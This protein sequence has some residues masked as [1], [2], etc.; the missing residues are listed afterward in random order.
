MSNQVSL[1]SWIKN[2]LGINLIVQTFEKQFSNGFYFGEILHVY[3][4]NP[5]FKENFV[6]RSQP[7]YVNRNFEL[8]RPLFAN[9]LGID[10]NS[11]IVKDIIN[12]RVGV[13]KK[14]ILKMRT[15]LEDKYEDN[16]KVSN[17][18]FLTDAQRSLF[19]KVKAQELN[20][21]LNRIE[22]RMVPF[23]EEYI[24]QL[25]RAQEIREQEE[26]KYRETI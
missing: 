23:E 25:K 10:L 3:L 24:K 20:P 1:Q 14:L 26:Q 15:V 2:T 19:Q 8:L 7:V 12:E 17:K 5:Q 21:T 16:L 9:Y 22:L 11:D 13:A 18:D 6:N 4:L